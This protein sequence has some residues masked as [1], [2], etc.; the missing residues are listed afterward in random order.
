M[1]SSILNGC[2]WLALLFSAHG[3]AATLGELR[4]SLA[5]GDVQVKTEDTKD[6]SPAA[7]NLPLRAGD[8]LWVPAGGRAEVEGRNGTTIR[9]DAET[10]VEILTLENEAA[11]FYLSLG[12]I[13]VEVFEP[14]R[15]TLQI[16]TPVAAVRVYE[17]AT[18]N[19]GL[20]PEG[21]TE[22]AV[23]R[24]TLFAEKQDGG[25]TR[26]DEGKLLL[27]DARRA[28]LS[29]LG[30]VDDWEKWN[31]ERDRQRAS[32]RDNARY[33][34]PELAGY[35]PQLNSYGHWEETLAYGHVWTPTEQLPEN[36][37]PYRH[38]RWVWLR[39]DYVWVA[40]EPWGWMPYHYGRWSYIPTVGWCWVPPA[41]GAVYWGPGYVGWVE[42]PTYIGWVPLAPGETYY[43]YGSFGP[44]SVDI[45][46]T[47]RSRWQVE[48]RYRNIYVHN[49]STIIHRDTF[50]YGKH[51]RFELSENP[52][53]S[54]RPHLGRPRLEPTRES[55]LV[56]IRSIPLSHEPP[57]LIRDLELRDL[58][59]RRHFVPERGRSVFRKEG[60]AITLS[61]EER[62]EPRRGGHGRSRGEE[63]FGR[64]EGDKH[65][66][67][68]R[69]KK[70]PA[71][72]LAPPVVPP[73]N[74][75]L[76]LPVRPTP[77][78]ADNDENRIKNKRWRDHG[79]PEPK[80]AEQPPPEAKA[81][82]LPVPSVPAVEE[83]KAPAPLQLQEGGNQAPKPPP[84]AEVAP[85]LGPPA[86]APALL[87]APSTPPVPVVE[88]KKA[89][90]PASASESGGQVLLPGHPSEKNSPSVLPVKPAI[91]LPV[92]STPPPTELPPRSEASP[93]TVLPPA[94]NDEKPIKSERWRD[95]LRPE[96][97]A[98]EQA[99]VK[100]PEAM[101]RTTAPALPT[102]G[103]EE[104]RTQ[105]EGRRDH[106]RPE[107]PA[108]EQAIAPK[109][110][111]PIYTPPVPAVAPPP[112]PVVKPVTPAPPPPPPPPVPTLKP[113]A[114][115]PPAP[116]PPEKKKP[117]PP[118]DPEKEKEGVPR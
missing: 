30:P 16:D 13:Y 49:G 14:G 10:S 102:L 4:L 47:D 53:L 111:P 91:T 96:R 57:R 103:G 48:E 37:A 28:E 116:A 71:A 65:A 55:R 29:P 93:A 72:D 105:D 18:F 108:L 43:G 73:A 59:R 100:A 56:T 50:L 40:Q 92:R 61:V 76:S 9:L 67:P 39:G 101:P 84:A 11:Q 58:S 54:Q 63:S 79:R 95:H 90:V 3:W 98:P 82:A 45:F 115:P 107:R 19:L 89:P 78:P 94:G 25:E 41:A 87:L 20:T 42:T 24:G 104:K 2:F 15:A 109:P 6:W 99:P 75:A 81:P 8:R 114:P 83:K 26:V 38:G 21:E 12:Q 1:K 113:G 64:R 23:F 46:A 69:E 44:N 34:P 118:G 106:G 80:A 36:W 52:F 74:P 35:G 110:V 51:R 68:E 27:L 5:E 77:P 31:R 60:A 66:G 33:L 117:L 62:H 17:E 112:P 97:S 86:K 88:E 22:L 7:I 85:P 70:A 32:W